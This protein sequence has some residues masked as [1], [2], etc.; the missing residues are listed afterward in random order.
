MHID[1]EVLDGALRNPCQGV[2]NDRVRGEDGEVGFGDDLELHPRHLAEHHRKFLVGL[3]VDEDST[4]R[5]AEVRAQVEARGQKLQLV[6][7][8]CGWYGDLHDEE[9]SIEVEG[10]ARSAEASGAPLELSVYDADVQVEVDTGVG[11]T[12][13]GADKVEVEEAIFEQEVGPGVLNRIL[14]TFAIRQKSDS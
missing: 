10:L 8:I 2:L 11:H 6:G 1:R 5:D 9:E 13:V 4:S 12:S 14:L 3:E 7:I